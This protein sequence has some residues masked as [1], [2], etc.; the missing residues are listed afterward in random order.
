MIRRDSLDV[1]F[2]EFIRRRAIISTGGCERCLT[3]KFDIQ[4][5]DGSVLPA[6]KQL[7]T[8]HFHGRAKKSTRWDPDNA[9]GICGAC[10]MYLGAHPLEHVEFFRKRLTEQGLD[11]LNARARLPAKYIDKEAIRLYLE[12][13]TE[14]LKGLG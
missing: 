6:W 11:L 13:E 3:P 7:Q 14:Y 2:S 8:S 12:K 1:L 4:K 9:C 10:H 5:E